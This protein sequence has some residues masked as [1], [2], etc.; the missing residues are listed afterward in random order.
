[1]SVDEIRISSRKAHTLL[2]KLYPQFQPNN[3]FEDRAVVLANRKTP[4]STE[5]EDDVNVVGL[6]LGADW[7]TRR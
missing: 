5:D 2:V 4:V 7:R 1:M 6:V 3:E